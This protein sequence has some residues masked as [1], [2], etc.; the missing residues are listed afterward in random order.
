MLIA[1]GIVNIMYLFRVLHDIKSRGYTWFYADI[2]WYVTYFWVEWKVYG[3]I[4]GELEQGLKPNYTLDIFG[5]FLSSQLVSC[6]SHYYGGWILY[7]LPGY[8]LIKGGSFLMSYMSNKSKNSMTEDE[9][10]TETEAKRLA[11]KERKDARAEKMGG[12]RYKNH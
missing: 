6:I 2:I 8:V 10:P 5:V 4:Y 9:K 3:M 7:L 12:V 1:L 11:K